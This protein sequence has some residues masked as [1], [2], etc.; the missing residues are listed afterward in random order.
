MSPLSL[1]KI[2]LHRGADKNACFPPLN[3][4]VLHF[5]VE[6]TWLVGVRYLLEVSSH[7]ACVRFS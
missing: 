4:T 6:M 5:C 7:C 2:L 1:M 3:R